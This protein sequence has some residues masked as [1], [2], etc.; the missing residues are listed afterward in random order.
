MMGP[1]D[2]KRR[3]MKA[4]THRD[5][6]QDVFD[7]CYE[8][9]MPRRMTMSD[10]TPGNRRDE[11][12]FDE[13]AVTGVQEFASKL[14]SGMIPAFSQWVDLRAGQEV[15]ADQRDDSRCRFWDA[16]ARLETG[17]LEQSNQKLTELALEA[18]YYGF[19]AADLLNF[20][21]TICP[22]EPNVTQAQIDALSVLPGFQ[23]ALELRKAGIPN[24]S[25][26]EWKIAVRP[27][28]REGLRTAA[29]L[30]TRENWPDMAIFALGNSGD[31]RWYEWRFPLEYAGLVEEQASKRNLDS[32]WVMGLMR[33]ES[34][35]AEDALSSAGA[36]GLMQVM[37]GTAK[38]LAKQHSFNYTGLQQ[39]MQAENNIEFGT[40]YLRDLLNRFGD[41]EVLVTGSYNAGPHVV[42]RWLAER[43]TDDPSIW[44]ETLPY[45]ETRDYI[46][47]VLAFSTIYDWRMQRPVTRVSSRMP[48]FDTT[49]I[50][51]SPTTAASAEIVCRTPG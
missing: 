18:N 28:D 26:S 12:I 51:N 40:A 29:A 23:R 45:F 33:S 6:F 30:S 39:L 49:K 35:M 22:E 44:V 42:D 20:P 8:L 48:G 3:Y 27:L 25:R 50:G 41:N 7:D 10:K 11:R 19:L 47:R 9:A 24:W 14:Q 34:A 46:P 43:K 36:R 37:P 2:I 38:L 17:D 4:S 15:P 31:L 5:L 21:Y 1:E 13:T 16:R 32:A